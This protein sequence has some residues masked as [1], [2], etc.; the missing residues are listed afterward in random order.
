MSDQQPDLNSFLE[1]ATA[2][3]EQLVSARN[4]A[5]EQVVAGEA[6][7]GLVKVEVTGGMQ[8]RSVHI[9]PS[10]TDDVSMLEDVVLAALHDAVTKVHDV[11]EAAVGNLFD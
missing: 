11:N 10:L 5:A 2:L 7:N 9:D 8:F 1:Q 3:Q 6:G 4:S